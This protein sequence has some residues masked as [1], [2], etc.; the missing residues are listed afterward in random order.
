[1]M[2]SEMMIRSVLIFQWKKYRRFGKFIEDLERVL[3]TP[4]RAMRF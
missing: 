4:D 2:I 1:M 3:E